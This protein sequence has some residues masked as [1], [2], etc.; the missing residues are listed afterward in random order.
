MNNEKKY[1]N[2]L[3]KILLK[4]GFNRNIYKK[5]KHIKEVI[6]YLR[7]KYH[8][9]FKKTNN[10]VSVENDDIFIIIFEKTIEI[11]V[12]IYCYEDN[13]ENIRLK[14]NI[15]KNTLENIK[16]IEKLLEIGYRNEQT[17]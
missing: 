16:N 9:T 1:R 3:K 12:Y 8:D 11:V 6:K 5:G 13:Y 14:Y 2:K 15:D 4:N 7:K 17:N 10:Y